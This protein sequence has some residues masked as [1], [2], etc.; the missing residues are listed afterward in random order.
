VFCDDVL[1]HEIW[2][3]E[4]LSAEWTHPLVLG[5]LLRVGENELLHLRSM[6][7]LRNNVGKNKNNNRGHKIFNNY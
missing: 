5:D 1:A 6:M 4:L 2:T 7:A 3:L